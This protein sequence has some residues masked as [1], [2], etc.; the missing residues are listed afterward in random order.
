MENILESWIDQEICTRC[1][2]CLEV[3]PSNVIGLNKANQVDFLTERKSICIQCGQCMAICRSGACQVK[4][5]SYDS[6]HKL[7][8]NL[9]TFKD[10]LDLI[11]TRR[12]VRNFTDRPVPQEVINRVI[13]SV[14]YAPYGAAP[15]KMHIT[16]INNRQKIEEALQPIADFL[17]NIVK[18]ME[19]PIASFMMKRKNGIEKYS[20]I[21]NHLYPIAKKGNYKL[22]YGDRISRGAPALIIFHADRSAEAHTTNSLIYA[23]YAMLAAQAIGLGSCMIEIIPAAINRLPEVRDLFEI[24]GGHEATISLAL[25]YPKYKYKRTVRREEHK[26]HIIN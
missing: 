5:L 7:P 21:K 11:S 10:Y 3:C 12:S 8:E 9:I 6:F 24:P 18:W 26:I 14:C 16:V 13:E 4:G 17:D 15:E 22:E 19:N 23:T 20:T 2:L 1:K 25:G